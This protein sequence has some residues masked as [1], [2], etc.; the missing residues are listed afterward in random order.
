MRQ[1]SIKW[2][3]ILSTVLVTAVAILVAISLL[4]WTVARELIKMDDQVLETRL[5]TVRNIIQSGTHIETL[6]SHEVHEYV[7]EI[8][9]A[10]V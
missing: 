5:E 7:E 3:L 6:L 10:H 8:G 2:Q 4:Y 9:R 1:T